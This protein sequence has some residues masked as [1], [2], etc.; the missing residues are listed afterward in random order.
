METAE[1]S[2]IWCS[3]VALDVRVV[4][5]AWERVYLSMASIGTL[6]DISS[7]DIAIQPSHKSK[8]TQAMAEADVPNQ[9]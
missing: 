7:R 6:E 3:Q 9:G 1:S 5:P 2:Q 4:S 8:E